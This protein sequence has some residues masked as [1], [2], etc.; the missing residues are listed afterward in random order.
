MEINSSKKDL[1]EIE[2]FT[3]DNEDDDDNE[4]TTDELD[5]VKANVRLFSMRQTEYVERP[6]K[7]AYQKEINEYITQLFPNKEKIR[8]YVDNMFLTDIRNTLNNKVDDEKIELVKNIV[9]I[10]FIIHCHYHIFSSFS[11]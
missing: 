9:N 1:I 2:Y 6:I 10:F 8:K 5:Q 4:S 11:C 7:E 3:T